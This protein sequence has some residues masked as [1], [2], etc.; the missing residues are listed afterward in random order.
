MNQKIF[1]I[2][3]FIETPLGYYDKINVS[4]SISKGHE[5]TPASQ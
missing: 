1:V 3:N 5:G 2:D 4:G